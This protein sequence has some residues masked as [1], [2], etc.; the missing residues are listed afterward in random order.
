M[1]SGPID[2]HSEYS[3]HDVVAGTMPDPDDYGE[4]VTDHPVTEFY[5]LHITHLGDGQYQIVY[6]GH[7]GTVDRF[8]ADDYGDV[9]ELVDDLIGYMLFIQEE[10]DEDVVDLAGKMITTNAKRAN[11][12]PDLYLHVPE[13]SPA[14]LDTSS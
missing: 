4:L 3:L 11:E 8:T 12:D 7:A 5:G 13:D 1:G 2:P 9:L 10:S 14:R 6:D